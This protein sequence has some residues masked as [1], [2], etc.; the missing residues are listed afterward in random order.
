MPPASGSGNPGILVTMVTKS[1]APTPLAPGV[2]AYRPRPRPGSKVSGHRAA[3]QVPRTP[4]AEAG[5]RG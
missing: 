1:R 5:G 2:G 4:Q 3:S